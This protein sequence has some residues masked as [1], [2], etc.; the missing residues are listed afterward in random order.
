[1]DFNETLLSRVEDAGLN[2]SAPPQQRWLDGWLLRTNPGEARRARCVNALATGRLPVDEK[3]A[4]A[5]QWFHECGVP[6]MVRITRFTQPAHLDNTLA[7]RGWPLLGNT[8]VLVLA[9][10]ALP[11]AAQPNSA[12]DPT[13][14]PTTDAA[15]DPATDAAPPEGLQ[16]QT[17]G[18]EA[19]AAVVG[20]LRSSPAD[21]QRAHAERLRS[22]PVPYSGFALARKDGQVLA[23]GQ[24]AREGAMVGLYDIFTHPDARGLGLSS[25]LC[26]R[27]LSLA[28][29]NGVSLAYLQ[30]E[31]D[32]HAAQA[33][34][35]RLG[36]AYGYS[37]HYRQAPEAG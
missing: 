32:N 11:A 34:Y 26:K 24:S 22:S 7:Q 2:A 27:M 6:M 25:W 12:A 3:L 16:W 28:T 36:F 29:R 17:L 37:Y 13:T 15:T 14:D 4:L 31:A 10:P 23:C 5:Q 18:A 1:M 20:K 9:S 30:V 21:Q 8:H 33:V 19:Y 35:R